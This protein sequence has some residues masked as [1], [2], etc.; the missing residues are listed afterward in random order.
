MLRNILEATA[1][2]WRQRSLEDKSYVIGMVLGTISTVHFLITHEGSALSLCAMASFGFGFAIWCR[3]IYCSR[4]VSKVKGTVFYLFH[5]CV[6]FISLIPARSLVGLAIGLPPQ[7][8]DLTVLMLAAIIYPAILL[9]A[10]ISVLVIGTIISWLGVGIVLA[11]ASTISGILVPMPWVQIRLNQW[12]SARE[13]IVKQVAAKS[14][15]AFAV[16]IVVA[17]L[18]T[19]IYEP[20][21]RHQNLVRLI[22]YAVDYQYAKLYPG[23]EPGKKFHLH[24]NAVVSYAELDGWDVKIRV[25]KVKES[26]CL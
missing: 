13:K 24:D 19:V 9:M 17:Y 5:A 10:I 8:F 1:N 21:F 26:P 2:K 12:K 7:D 20:I 3:S 11:I 25:G 15:G 4:W 6:G 16:A 18:A 23:I 22:A 14:I